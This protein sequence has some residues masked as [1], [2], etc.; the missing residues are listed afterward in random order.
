MST[1]VCVYD[2]GS[3]F[4][5]QS[6]FILTPVLTPI[7]EPTGDYRIQLKGSRLG[8]AERSEMLSLY[9][10]EGDGDNR[11]EGSTYVSVVFTTANIRRGGS[12]RSAMVDFI[13][14]SSAREMSMVR[15]VPICMH[16]ST[17]SSATLSINATR[18]PRGSVCTTVR[19]AI[20]LNG[21][22]H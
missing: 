16:A 22:L 6:T 7:G 8:T 5:D 2:T 12:S 15:L 4:G 3:L 18:A 19:T 9:V 10:S 14:S 20:Y 21:L 13:F 11:D 1:R 17:S